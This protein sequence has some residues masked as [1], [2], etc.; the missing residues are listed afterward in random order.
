MINYQEY[1]PHN[2]LKDKIDCYWILEITGNDIK[3]DN[4]ERVIPLGFSELIFHFGDYYS[5][6]RNDEYIELEKSLFT[7]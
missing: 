4:I 3:P 1:Q 7:G 2:S 6:K 5:I